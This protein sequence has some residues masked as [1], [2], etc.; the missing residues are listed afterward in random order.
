MNSAPG[1]RTRCIRILRH[2]SQCWRIPRGLK[3]DRKLHCERTSI[4]QTD[5]P[6]IA[7][8]LIMNK[9]HAVLL[10]LSWIC[11][12]AMPPFSHGA[13]TFVLRIGGLVQ[14]PIHLTYSDLQQFRQKEI[15]AYVGRTASLFHAVTLRSLLELAKPQEPIRESRHF[16]EEQSWRTDG[17]LR[18]RNAFD[19]SKQSFHCGIRER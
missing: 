19:Y 4:I 13:E 2:T 3:A 18:W 9:K 14:S 10:I 1:L 6:E 8:M 12:F 11:L 16:A 5:L 7:K 15:S 17:P